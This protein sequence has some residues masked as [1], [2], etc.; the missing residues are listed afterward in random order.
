M[1]FNARQDLMIRANLLI[2]QK[3]GE[4]DKGIGPDGAGYVPAAQN[5]NSAMGMEC[6]HCAFFRGTQG[7]TIVRGDIEPGALCKLWVIP[8]EAIKPKRSL[9]GRPT[10]IEVVG[11]K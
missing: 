4:W 1:A 6:A 11:V 5:P 9:G 7:C 10:R 2:A 3:V 8:V